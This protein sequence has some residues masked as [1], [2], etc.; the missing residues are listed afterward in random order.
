MNPKRD[1]STEPSE[2]EENKSNQA[3]AV[4]YATIRGDRM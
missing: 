1:F 2:A 4:Q 3:I